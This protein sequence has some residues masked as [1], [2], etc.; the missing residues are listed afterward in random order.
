MTL[1]CMT[2]VPVAFG[3]LLACSSESDPQTPSDD[4]PSI[5]QA[6]DAGPDTSLPGND[7]TTG[8]VCEAICPA[9]YPVCRLEAEGSVRCQKG[10]Q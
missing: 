9:D 2:Y 8:A 3:L 4:C 10:C 6:I 7:W 1:P 5:V